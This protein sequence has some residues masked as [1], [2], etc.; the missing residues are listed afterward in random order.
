MPSPANR[1]AFFFEVF[2]DMF[3]V[4]FLHVIA[5]GA[6][7]I[8]LH[9]TGRWKDAIGDLHLRIPDIGP[10]QGFAAMQESF[11]NSYHHGRLWRSAIEG[12]RL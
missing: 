10:D 5:V 12:E 3:I 7:M 8:G 9:L 1:A 4:A 6:H 11:F 2:L